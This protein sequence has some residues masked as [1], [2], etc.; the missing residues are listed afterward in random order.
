MVTDLLGDGINSSLSMGGDLD[1]YDAS[2]CYSEV[3]SPVDFQRAVHNTFGT[4]V[5]D[6]GY[7]MNFHRPRRAR[8]VIAA[9]PASVINGL[10][11]VDTMT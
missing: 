8:G 4:S 6:G 5:N 10:L 9:V 3:G 7:C 2:V 1:W 11:S